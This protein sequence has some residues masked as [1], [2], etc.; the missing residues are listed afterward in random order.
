VIKRSL[1]LLVSALTAFVCAPGSSSAQNLVGRPTSGLF[2]I[3]AGVISR[4][5][6]DT[7]PVLQSEIGS[8]GQ[9][10]ADFPMG[11]EFYFTTAF[12]FYYIEISRSN[13]IMLEASLGG[14]KAFPLRRAHMVL[15]PGTSVGFAYLAEMGDLPAVHL[16]TVK[17]FF[18]THF[19]IDVRKAWV[20]E[21]TWFYGPTG[22]NGETTLSFGPGV[23]LRVGLA[24]R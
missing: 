1:T 9:V 15:E 12:D 3:K 2:G 17:L 4:M 6:L 20:G 21:L 8:C 10:Y 5:N 19:A 22:D 14:K 13:Q 24:F 18:E 7:Y 11:R 23:M 16:L